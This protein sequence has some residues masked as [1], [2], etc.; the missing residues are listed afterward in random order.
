MQNIIMSQKEGKRVIILEKLKGGEISQKTAGYALN[1]TIRQT[2]RIFYRYLEYGVSGLIHKGRGRVGNRKINKLEID[3]V[4]SLVREK[5]SDFGP[6][7]ALEK[8]EELHQVKFGVD[9]LRVAMITS[10]IWKSRSRKHS[11][12]HP[13]RPRRECEGELIQVDGSPFRWLEDRGETGMFSL[14]VAVDDATSK[15][16]QL[17]FVPS[18]S[19]ESYFEFTKGYLKTNG[20]PLA[21]YMDKHSVFRVN[22][23]QGEGTHEDSVGLTQFG[24]A[25]QELDIA[26]IFANTPQAKGRVENVNGTLQDRL[27]KEMRLR[28]IMTIEQANAYLPEFM[29]IFNKRF[30]KKPKNSTDLHRLISAKELNQLDDIFTI[31]D[32]RVISKNLTIQ[33]KNL[34]YQIQSKRPAYAMR[35]TKVEVWEHPRSGEVTLFHQGR[36]L[37]YTIFKKQPKTTIVDSKQLNQ[38]VDIIKNQTQHK[39]QSYFDQISELSWDSYSTNQG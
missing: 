31:K 24:R 10:G 2:R 11:N 35:K 30:A 23:K 39:H 13:S 25:M 19:I 14:L 20:K 16:K 1:L 15:I 33:Y 36:K 3:R 34:E 9:T 22:S 4:I 26:M 12:N 37:D 7:F 6:T 28:D 38:A 21:W 8:L 27:T 5:Y 17:L 18:E 32:V 29:E